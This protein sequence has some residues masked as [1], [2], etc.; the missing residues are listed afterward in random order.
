MTRALHRGVGE[1]EREREREREE[2]QMDDVGQ[3]LTV[4]MSSFLSFFTS[5]FS[6]AT[7]RW[8]REREEEVVEEEE[9]G[10]GE[11]GGNRRIKEKGAT[12]GHVSP[13]LPAC[14]PHH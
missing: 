9:E 4:K 6:H 3:Q 13:G 7:N 10:D 14:L 1:R 2:K 12:A 11:N 8:R 5:T